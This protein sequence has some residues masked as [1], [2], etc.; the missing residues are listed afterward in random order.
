M[1]AFRHG[2][3]R[4]CVGLT[5]ATEI[6]AALLIGVIVVVNFLGVF[7]R[8]GL[9]DPIGWPEETMRYSM[10]WATFL[11]SSAALYRGEHMV[12]NLFENTTI[13][14]FRWALHIIVLL[15]VASFC[16]IC[17]WYGWPL[18]VRNWNQV[19][20]TMNLPMFW[21]YAAVPVGCALMLLKAV[22]MVLMPPGY[23]ARALA[24]T[25]VDPEI[26]SSFV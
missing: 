5:Y 19:S 20:P 8:Y 10:I 21:P 7:Y 23:S 13:V 3:H 9:R 4:F 6:A 1:H 2:L 24:D 11:G 14:W 15:T 26:S 12:L 22:A 16:A 18:A 17:V 25:S